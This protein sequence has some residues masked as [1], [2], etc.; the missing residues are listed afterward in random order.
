M[1]RLNGTLAAAITLASAA[2]AVATE[3]PA[4]PER[5]NFP[6]LNFNVPNAAAMRVKLANGVPCY[7]AEDSI[8][9]SRGSRSSCVP[10]AW[11]RGR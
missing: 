5:L 7:I 10:S 6:P 9:F 1:R 2:S 8:P 4:R 11:P 3:I